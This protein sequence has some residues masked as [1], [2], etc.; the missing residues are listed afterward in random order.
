MLKSRGGSRISDCE[1]GGVDFPFL[2]FLSPLILLFPFSL[3]PP[4]L[5]PLSDPYRIVKVIVNSKG[6]YR[7]YFLQ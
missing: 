1:P 2:L 5:P 4:L 3:S 6:V 7:A